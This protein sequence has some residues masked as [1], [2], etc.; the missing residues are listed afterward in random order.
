MPRIVVGTTAVQI[1]RPNKGRKKW[2]I[3][4]IPSSIIAGNTGLVFIGIG[5]PP[6]SA[7]TATSYNEVLNSGSATYRNATVA[8]T[9]REIQEAIWAIADAADQVINVSE[10]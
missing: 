9:E 4:F 1:L 3:E 7:V 5:N 8:S 6:G 10:E 2:Y